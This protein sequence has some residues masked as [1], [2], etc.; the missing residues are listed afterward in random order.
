MTDTSNYY[1]PPEYPQKDGLIISIGEMRKL[2]GEK[3]SRLTDNQVRD[4]ILTLTD[5]ADKHLKLI[6]STKIA[7]CNT[8]S[9]V[10]S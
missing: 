4:T 1:T 8:K 2:L 6:G 10:S 3:G 7:G 9:R 5:M